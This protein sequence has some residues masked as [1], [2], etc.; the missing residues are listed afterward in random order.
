VAGTT[1]VVDVEDRDK[2]GSTWGGTPGLKTHSTTF[3]FAAI[4]PL[5]VNCIIFKDFSQ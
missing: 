1:P 2:D 3:S 4:P 5:G